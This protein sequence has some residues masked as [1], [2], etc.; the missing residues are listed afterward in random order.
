METWIFKWEKNGFF[1]AQGE[2][3]KN[4]GIIRC[5]SIQ[6]NI[7]AS[8]PQEIRLQYAKGHSGDVGNDGADAMA[9]MGTLL[10]AVEDRDWEALELK[11]LEQLEKTFVGADPAPVEVDRGFRFWIV[12]F[13]LIIVFHINLPVKK[14]CR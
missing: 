3:V 6:L 11:L 2:P 14:L 4:A 10:P 13:V 5:T 8:Y 1:S 7:R 9:N 12:L